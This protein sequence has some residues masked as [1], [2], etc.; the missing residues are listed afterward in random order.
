MIRWLLLL[1]LLP[2]AALAQTAT[3]PAPMVEGQAD[4]PVRVVTYLSFTCPHCAEREAAVAA[5]LHSLIERG[6]VV[7]ETRHALRDPL[8][9]AVATVA[10]CQGPAA[11]SDNRDA[12]FAA[13]ADWM[14]EAD[15]YVQANRPALV[16]LPPDDAYLALLKG[17]GVLTLMAGRGLTQADAARCLA[18][19][20]ERAALLA[21]AQ[22]AWGDRAIPGTP[23][24]LV[25]GVAATGLDWPTLATA[26]QAASTR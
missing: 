17:S 1:A 7:A 26:I 9:L 5:P 2:T 16:A 3:A 13:Q 23:Y 22:E 20:A 14:A 24:T 11:Y 15:R 6:E 19:P 18:D 21:E 10:R 25:N 8:D 12:L 4:A